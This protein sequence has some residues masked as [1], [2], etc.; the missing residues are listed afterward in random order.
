MTRISKCIWCSSVSRCARSV[1]QDS[2]P[3]RASSCIPFDNHKDLS[4]TARIKAG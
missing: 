4:K 2:I 3:P 1:Q